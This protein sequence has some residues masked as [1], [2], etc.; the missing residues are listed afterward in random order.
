MKRKGVAALATAAVGLGA[1]L[2]AQRSAVQRR[3]RTDP[4]AGER[5]GKR[6]GHSPRTISLPDGARLFIEEVGPGSRSGAV[7]IHGSAMRNDMWH[8]QM[9]GL[10]DHRLVFYDLRGHGL[11]QPKGDADFS[12]R[13]LAEDLKLVIDEAD[14]DEVVVVGHSI[15]GMIALEYARLNPTLLGSKVR[16]LVLLN[17]THRPAVET[18]LGGASLAR[19]ERFLRKPLDAVG[20]RAEYV[21]RLRKIIKPTDSI[22]MLVAAAAF[23]PHASA[24]QIDFAYDMMADTPADVLFDLVRSYRD[25]DVTDHLEEIQVPALVVGATHD[26]LTVLAASE[27]L[28]AHLP[29]AELRVL[30]GCGHMSMLE[31]HRDLNRLLTAFLDD[32]FGTPDAGRHREATSERE[33]I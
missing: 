20:S 16:G 25:F 3:R 26:R 2:V 10:G 27:H 30:N 17:T 1:G 13:T 5:F 29:Q 21:E 9:E 28:A 14:L 11:S 33:S 24:K 12:V 31:R 18:L 8:Y 23:G 7:F 15:G 32:A 4:E 22:F 6:R 19:V